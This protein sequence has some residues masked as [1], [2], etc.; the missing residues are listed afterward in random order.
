MKIGPAT[1]GFSV[2]VTDLTWS[3]CKC[4]ILDGQRFHQNGC[5]TP[6]QGTP[7]VTIWDTRLIDFHCKHLDD[8]RHE[9]R[10]R[11]MWKGLNLYNVFFGG[12]G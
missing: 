7:N 4:D 12:K 11:D 1:D 8:F 5:V 2:S 10:P 9:I 6:S 3:T